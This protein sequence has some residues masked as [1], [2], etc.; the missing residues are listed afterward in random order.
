MSE[1][2]FS[3]KTVTLAEDEKIVS[4]DNGVAETMNDYVSNIVQNLE[5]KGYQD[6]KFSMILT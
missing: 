3:R 5:I 6:E 4:E 2:R 1:K